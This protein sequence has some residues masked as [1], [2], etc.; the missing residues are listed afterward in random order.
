MLLAAF[1]CGCVS[2]LMGNRTAI[3]LL[4]SMAF[5][6]ALIYAGVPFNFFFW[7]MIDLAVIFTIICMGMQK[8]EI[9]MCDFAVIGLFAPAWIAYQMGGEIRFWG[10]I[11]VV[12][13]QFAIVFPYRQLM[14]LAKGWLLA[15][16]NDDFNMMVAA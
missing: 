16:R 5:S 3:P 8:R 7:W 13:M 6:V 15:F 11:I 2:V 1:L 4:A 10:S 12:V 14:K 9:D